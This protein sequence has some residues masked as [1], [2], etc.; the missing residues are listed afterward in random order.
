MKPAV[1]I[2]KSSVFDPFLF[3]RPFRMNVEKVIRPPLPKPTD[4]VHLVEKIEAIQTS[5]RG[6]E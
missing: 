5:T 4:P 1:Q 6:V 3:V 2:V